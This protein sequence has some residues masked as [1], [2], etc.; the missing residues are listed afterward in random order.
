MDILV[1]E[2]LEHLQTYPPECR[3]RLVVGCL[4]GTY[5]SADSYQ[6]HRAED[7]V[8]ELRITGALVRQVVSDD[9]AVARRIKEERE[10][11]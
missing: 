2:L 10:G 1:R 5:A 6:M 7:G 11:E 3:V 8:H 9:D 4:D